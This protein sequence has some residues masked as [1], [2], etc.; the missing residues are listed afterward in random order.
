MKDN[1]K[2]INELY[3]MLEKEILTVE[4]KEIISNIGNNVRKQLDK[5]EMN[6]Q[7]REHTYNHIYYYCLALYEINFL[8]DDLFNTILAN[9][10]VKLDKIEEHNYKEFMENEN[11][12]TNKN[13]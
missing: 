2:M 7:N 13:N 9:F 5:F 4:R 10:S 12:T 6:L 3:E 11:T 1:T 8:N